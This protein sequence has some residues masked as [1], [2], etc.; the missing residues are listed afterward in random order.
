MTGDD[1]SEIGAL[2]LLEQQADLVVCRRLEELIDTTEHR[3]P[4]TPEPSFMV[5]S[6]MRNP[7]VKMMSKPA[8]ASWSMLGS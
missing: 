6:V 7:T 4:G 8:L 1:A 3:R 5:V 2:V